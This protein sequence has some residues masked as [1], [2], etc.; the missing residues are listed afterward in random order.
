MRK[1]LFKRNANAFALSAIVDVRLFEI[2]SAVIEI[3]R[4][5]DDSILTRL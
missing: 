2:S 4:P 1:F 3:L 5:K